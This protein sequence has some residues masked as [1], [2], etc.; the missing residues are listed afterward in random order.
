MDRTATPSPPSRRPVP[1]SLLLTLILAGSQ[2][3]HAVKNEREEGPP[4]SSS[5]THISR[6]TLTLEQSRQLSGGIEV[7][8]LQRANLQPEL[9]V[10]GRIADISPLLELRTRY[11]ATLADYKIADA[12]R[13]LSLKNRD[14]LAQLSREAIIATKELI[15]A[16]SALTADETRTAT[17]RQRLQELREEALHSWGP[18]LFRLAIAEDSVLWEQLLKR[19]K[20]LLLIALPANA[21][22]PSGTR[23][24]AVARNR[25]R[26]NATRAEL[27]AAAP[28]TDDFIQGETYFF[29]IVAQHLRTGMRVDAWIPV[30]TG[31]AT[32]SFLPAS[33]II[34]YG[35]SPWVYVKTG[36]DGFMRR[37]VNDYHEYGDSWFVRTGFEP[38]DEVATVGAQLLLSEEMRRQIPR[39]DDD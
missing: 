26:A 32:G 22:M 16:E 34:W 21:T 7:I 6:P 33:A 1:A 29:T 28:N 38:G 39:E 17:T 3:G 11:R 14:R 8:R 4:G 30:G 10:Q 31:P 2:P 9:G 20:V 15:H 18:E 24:I 19:Q 13:A 5:P 35:G 37:P 12:A 36:A 27:L 25:D 23:V